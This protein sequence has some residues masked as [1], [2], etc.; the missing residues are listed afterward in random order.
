MLTAQFHQLT[1]RLRFAFCGC[2]LK[3]ATSHFIAQ[4]VPQFHPILRAG[5][6]GHGAPEA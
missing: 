4:I 1:S 3:T 6:D 5:Y 2:K